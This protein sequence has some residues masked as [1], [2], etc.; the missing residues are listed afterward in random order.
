MKKPKGEESFH[1]LFQMHLKRE[2]K[3]ANFERLL[4]TFLN[5]SIVNLKN[6]FKHFFFRIAKFERI[7][8]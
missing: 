3:S 7:S 6:I 2:K 5:I 4:L 1:T 8:R